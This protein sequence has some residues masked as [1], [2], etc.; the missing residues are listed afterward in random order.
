MTRSRSP[1]AELPVRIAGTDEL[2]AVG[3]V[4]VLAFARDPVA[5]FVFSDPSAYRGGFGAF[6]RSFARPALAGGTAFA[7]EG[8][9]GA[10]LWMAPGMASDDSELMEGFSR[11][12]APEKLPTAGAL[13]EEMMKRHPEEPHWYLP[14]I[15]VDPA[16]QG[17]GIGSALL[18]ASLAR[19]DRDGL[20]A[21]LESTNPANVPLYLRHGFEA[22][23]TIEVGDVP[24]IVPMLRPAR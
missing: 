5:R 2:E 22:L 20:P 14:L 18:R 6:I 3:D 9:G 8:F 21:Y 23:K 17:R 12:V 13:M 4:L 10:S 24:Q 19:V 11:W 7:A 1:Q 15:G 16:L